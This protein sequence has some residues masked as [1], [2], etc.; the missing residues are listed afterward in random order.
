MRLVVD[1]QG[2]Q[3]PTSRFR[4]IGRYS[5]E[6]ALAMARHPGP[7]ELV[8]ALNGNLPADDL[9]AGFAPLLPPENIRAWFSPGRTAESDAT[10]TGRR[11]AAAVLRAEFL[12]GLQPDLVHVSSLFE[13]SSDDVMTRWP[14]N[15]AR[16]PMVATCYDLIPFIRRT[17][18]LDGPWRGMAANWYLNRLRQLELCDGLLAISE[19][20]R[21]EAIDHLGYRPDRVHNIRAGI[22]PLF[23]PRAL[24]PE[25]TEAL[26]TRYGLHPGFVLFVG[27]GDLR[28]NEAGL[29]AAYGLLPEAL[30][31]A[32][33][34][35]IVGKTDPDELGRSAAA[36]GVPLAQVALVRFVEEAD[37]PA[38]W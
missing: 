20:S 13:G 2:A 24:D 28:K 12:A 22:G 25:Q 15:R 32:H 23:A 27:A 19:S 17:D 1:L 6:L 18:Y 5:R 26:L 16:L 34:L 29:I 33:Q 9:L 3:G 4:G 14:S 11:D 37:L 36:A 35:V 10:A 38:L 21:R 8:V 30:R 31:A 7:H